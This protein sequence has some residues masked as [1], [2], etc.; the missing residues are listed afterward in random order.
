M[1]VLQI[2]TIS[3][4]ARSPYF[5]LFSRLGEYKPAWLDELLVDR[6]IFEYWAHAAC[7]IPIEDY[8]FF[9]RSMLEGSHS[10]FGEDWPRENQ[11]MLDQV[12]NHVR[13]NGPA[14]SADFK[15]EKGP[16]GWW[17]RKAE[18][19][20]LEYWYLHGRLGI[21]RRD[22]FQRVYD[23]T[24]RVMPSLDDTQ[25]P[26]KDESYRQFILKT[27]RALGI[28]LPAWV[29]DYYRLKKKF[30]LPLIQ[31][32]VTS[33][34]IAQVEIKGWQE[35]GLYLPE[36]EEL[37]KAAAHNELH[38]THTT[39]LSPFDPL[40]WDRDRARQLFDFDFTIQSYTPAA[41]RTYG[42]FP[43]PILHRGRLVGRL[44]AK[45]HRKDGRFEIKGFYLEPGMEPEQK[46]MREVMTAVNRC[47]EWHNTPEVFP[48][49]DLSA[50]I[51][52]AIRIALNTNS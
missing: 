41:K 13:E 38:A 28:A 25:L 2:D 34:E 24:E 23:L 45:A 14:R 52:T 11:V 30:A 19:W 46:L 7:F 3:V 36:N 48:G 8:P 1:G 15:S 4:V 35:P 20:A 17:N 6:E 16:G 26:A 50:D 9:R 12:L 10:Y 39:L 32:M 5:V 21:A 51:S 18:K 27:L 49:D 37:I 22:N 29:P 43:L 44:D 40:T 47:A 33:G 42:Y 31:Q